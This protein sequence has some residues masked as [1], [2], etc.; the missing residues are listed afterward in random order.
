MLNKQL[1]K[2]NVYVTNED[3]KTADVI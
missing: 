1:L 3:K 2:K